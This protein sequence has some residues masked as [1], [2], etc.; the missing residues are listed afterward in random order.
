[1]NCSDGYSLGARGRIEG[2]LHSELCGSGSS[3]SQALCKAE[4]YQHML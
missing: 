1:M 3:R 2:F 4:I